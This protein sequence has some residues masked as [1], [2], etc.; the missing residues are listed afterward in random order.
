[1]PGPCPYPAILR[2]QLEIPFSPWSSRLQL[3]FQ[4]VEKAPICAIVDDLLRARFDHAGFVQA[5]RVESEGVLVIVF[6]PPVVR[7]L[8]QCL[9]SIIVTRRETAIYEPSCR[10]WRVDDT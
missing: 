9:Q 4:L 2:P 10:A 1:M 6:A 7:Q 8:A 3:A 5:Q